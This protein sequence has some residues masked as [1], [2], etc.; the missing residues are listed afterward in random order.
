MEKKSFWQSPIKMA[1]SGVLAVV[2]LLVAIN[3]FTVVSVGEE[4]AV[5]SFGEVHT[6]KNYTGFNLVAFWWDI[7]S[8][9]L[10]HQTYS[11]DDVAVASKDKFKTSMD[12]AFT[13]AFVSGFAAQSRENTG[14]ESRYLTTHVNK[15][16]GSCLTKAGGEVLNSQAFFDKTTQE[17]MAVSVLDCVNTY[18]TDVGGYKLSVVQFSDIRLDPVVKKFMVKTKQRQEEETQADSELAIAETLA[19]KIVKTS[20][21]NLLAA[22]N[23]KQS[24][25][26][27][28]EGVKESMVLEA[29]GNVELNK[30]ITNGLVL[31]VEAKRWDGKRSQVVAGAGTEL[32]IDTRN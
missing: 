27:K 12:V 19:Q 32:L 10:Q 17:S 16:V 22:E 5:S 24:A 31:Y 29:E 6:D 21:A 26:L 3:S 11:M 28:A 14:Q 15:R 7:D 2:S 8:Y 9:N 23:D 1:V 4:A 18:L 30:S 25:V 20:E 13:G